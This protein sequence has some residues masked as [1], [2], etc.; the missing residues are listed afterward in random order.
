K[1][2]FEAKQKEVEKAVNPIMAKVYQS[3]GGDSAGD[4]TDNEGFDDEDDHDEL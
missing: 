4:A 3:S 1:E 2:D